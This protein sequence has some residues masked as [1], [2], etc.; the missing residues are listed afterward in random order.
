MVDL[1]QAF[2][3]TQKLL[4]FQ[5]LTDKKNKLNFKQEWRIIDKLNSI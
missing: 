4:V 3:I 2:L 5:F 1:M